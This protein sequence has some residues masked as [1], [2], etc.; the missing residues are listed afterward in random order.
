MWGYK[1][2]RKGG[3]AGAR[4]YSVASEYLE[5]G[6]LLNN[7]L[8]DYNGR[9]IPLSE[10]LMEG[11]SIAVLPVYKQRTSFVQINFDPSK[12]GM[13]N[14]S[15]SNGQIIKVGMMDTIEFRAFANGGNTVSGYE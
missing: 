12:G 3:L 1:I 4:Y 14:N 7:Q 2:E 8:K 5:V 9:T 13:D 6:E 10:V 15:F 11:N